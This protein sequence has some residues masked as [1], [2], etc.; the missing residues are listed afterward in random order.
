V[1]L[2]TQLKNYIFGIKMKSKIEYIDRKKCELKINSCGNCKKNWKKVVCAKDFESKLGNFNVFRCQISDIG[3]ISPY[4]TEKTSYLLYKGRKSADFDTINHSFIDNIKD[5][6][7]KNQIKKITSGIEV[8]SVLDF[9][10]GNGRFAF[11]SKK[12][13]QN[14]NVDAVDYQ[15]KSPILL[16]KKKSGVSYFDLST[17]NKKTKKYDVIILR[18]VLEHSYYP[19][20]LMKYLSKRLSKNGIIYVEVPNLDS[21]CAKIFGKYWKNYYVP[22]HIFNYSKSSFLRIINKA[23][24]ESKINKN[25]MPL[26]GNMISI[27]FNL[28]KYNVFVQFFGILLYPFQL[29]IEFVNGTSTCI[30]A[31]CKH[32]SYN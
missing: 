18:H 5:L 3:F 30:N 9:M 14:A 7:A 6:L 17:F 2:K 26:M 19:V 22:R 24:L 27:L 20:K 29:I 8:N 11:L 21:A 12:V 25:E 16:S 15:I 4:P 32:T 28:N 1:K 10:T 31:S 13:F 23:G